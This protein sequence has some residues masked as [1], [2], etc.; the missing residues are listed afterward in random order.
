MLQ[1]DNDN[2][3][4]EKGHKDISRVQTGLENQLGDQSKMPVRGQWDSPFM[5]KQQSKLEAN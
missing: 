3:C 5:S 2:T 1:N 4:Q